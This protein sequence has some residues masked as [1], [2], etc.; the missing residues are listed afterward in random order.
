F[1]Y[2]LLPFLWNSGNPEISELVLQILTNI[3]NSM[4]YEGCNQEMITSIPWWAS[5]D[6]AIPKI[7]D[8]FI[9]KATTT[10]QAKYAVQCLNAII[11]DDTEK[12]RVFGEILDSIKTSF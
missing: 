5:E 4:N 6:D 9:L 1:S 12:Q 11:N 3:G 8:K 7:I 2:Y 10:K